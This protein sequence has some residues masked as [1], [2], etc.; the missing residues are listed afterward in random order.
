M[1]ADEPSIS[2]AAGAAAARNCLVYLAANGLLMKADAKLPSVTTIV[3]GRPVTG[4]W[5]SHPLAHTIFFALRD[6]ESNPDLLLAKLVAGKDTFAHRRLWPEIAAIALAREPWQTLRLPPE[7][8]KL[9]KQVN[10]AG[11]IESDGPVARMLETRLLVHGIQFH[12]HEGRHRKHLE[13]W[14]QWASRASQPLDD[15]PSPAQAKQVFQGIWPGAKW[16]WTSRSA[17]PG[18]GFTSG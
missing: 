17:K 15:L 2:A 9:L 7:A 5:W 12:S 11:S 14:Q 10:T 18:R 13:S 4:S 8:V 6:L 3:A 1:N 16:P